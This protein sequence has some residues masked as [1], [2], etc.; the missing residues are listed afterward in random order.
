MKHSGKVYTTSLYDICLN[1]ST[2]IIVST[3]TYLHSL[4]L[5]VTQIKASPMGFGTTVHGTSISMIPRNFSSPPPDHFTH[6]CAKRLWV[7]SDG[8]SPGSR[9]FLSIFILMHLPSQC[10]KWFLVRFLIVIPTF[11]VFKFRQTE[12]NSVASGLGACDLLG[13][14]SREITII[15]L[16]QEAKVY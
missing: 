15:E 3:I 4:S 9:S 2:F 12:V 8:S 10:F 16:R 5:I 1:I 13:W 6:S 7:R 11:G 14:T